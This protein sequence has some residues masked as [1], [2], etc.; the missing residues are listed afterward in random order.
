MSNLAGWVIGGVIGLCVAAVVGTAIYV[1]VN[2]DTI[3]KRFFNTQP[4]SVTDKAI[5]LRIK[6]ASR[7]AFKID[8]LDEWDNPIAVFEVSGGEVDSS[9]K[10]GDTIKLKAKERS[11][12]PV[13]IDALDEWNDTIA[14]F[15]VSGDE[16]DSSLEVGDTITI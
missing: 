1:V 3:K 8:A 6:E 14:D 9:I 4:T 12:N 5:K 10:V 16:V 7:N 11:K 15:E 13:K 2:W